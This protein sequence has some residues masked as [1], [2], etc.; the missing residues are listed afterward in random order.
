MIEIKKISVE[1]LTTIESLIDDKDQKIG[2]SNKKITKEDYIKF[3]S[4]ILTSKS[5]DTYGFF[6]NEEFISF[7]S[8]VNFPNL[9]YYGILNFKVLKKYNFYDVTKNGFL[10]LKEHISNIKEKEKYYSFYVARAA[11][12]SKLSNKIIN[13]SFSVFSQFYKKYIVTIEELIPANHK[14]KFEYFNKALLMD[15]VFDEDFLIYK[16]TCKDEYRNIKV[17]RDIKL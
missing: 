8:C 15:K 1:D 7:M 5:Y 17:I 10:H 11:R 16:F 3:T 9:P 14:S 13:R 12:D 6:I 2:F 4:K